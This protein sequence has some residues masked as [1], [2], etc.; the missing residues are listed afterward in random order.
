MD[1]KETVFRPKKTAYREVT[2]IPTESVLH[3]IYGED[4]AKAKVRYEHLALMYKETFGEGDVA[5]FTAPG[6]TEII[7]NHTDHNGGK[8]LAG[9][10]TMDTIAAAAKRDDGIIN[11]VSEG[12]TPITLKAADYAKAPTCRGTLS[13]IAGMLEAC[14]KMGFAFGGF[15]A[16]VTTEVI[17]SAGVSSSASFEMLLC[18][19]LNAFF[20]DGKIDVADYARIGQYAENHYWEK[21]SGLMDQMACAVGGTIV[22]D[23]GGGVKYEKVDFSFDELGKDLIIVNTGKAGHADLSEEYS[24][25]PNEMRLVAAAFGKKN[26]C[27]VDEEEFY[28][29]IPELREQIKNDRAI[30]R[31]MHYFNECGRV[32]DAIKALENGKPE[33]IPEIMKESGRSS[34]ELL[35]NCFVPT[36]PE[37]QPI[38]VALGLTDRFI[39]KNHIDGTCRVHGGGFAG[40]IAVVL[41]KEN[42]ESYVEYM[43]PYVGRDAIH[44][45]GIRQTGAVE[46][47]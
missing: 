21:A 43:T 3:R 37:V 2:M 7:G 14:D 28:K 11:V 33:Q 38:C 44:V 39:Q 45:M 20:N 27:E 40:V 31:A 22:L 12:Y 19:I 9:S 47:K 4:T 17:S 18:A 5:Y 32:E 25:I 29:K 13:L 16:Y 42:T 36:M 10:I 46:V 1:L 26:L 24:S 6:R 23:F 34:W 30:L 41:P 35:Q 8:I 15:N